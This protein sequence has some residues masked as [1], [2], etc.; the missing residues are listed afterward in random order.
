M[1]EI[2]NKFGIDWKI[3]SAEIV[4]FLVLLAIL[5]LVFYKKIFSIVEERQKKINEGL[6]KSE[7]ADM[8][9]K[10]AKEKKK[11]II[12]NAR[13]EAKDKIKEAIE[14]AKEK[15]NEILTLAREEEVKIKINAV[16][17][18]EQIKQKIINSS[19]DEIAKIIVLGAEKILSNK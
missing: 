7:R 12:L 16:K 14:N 3:F 1:Q 19:K 10:E 15:E 17:D 6:D 8:E 11:E 2:I 5:S 13:K 4:N 9:L 18:G